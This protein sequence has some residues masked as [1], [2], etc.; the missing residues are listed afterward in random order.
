MLSPLVIGPLRLAISPLDV[1][2]QVLLPLA[3][4]AAAYALARLAIARMDLSPQ[5]RQRIRRLLRLAVILAAAVVLLALLTASFPK[6]LKSNL[7]SVWR[8]L[9]TPFITAGS[10]SISIVT[11]LLTIPVFLLANWLG[12]L[13]RLFLDRGL[14][15]RIVL[16]EEV[17]FTISNLVRYG[18]LV[19]AIIV[20][21]S[22]IGVNL[23]SMAVIFG[24]IGIGLGF[25]L[26]N[27][28]ANYVAGLVIFLERPLKEGDRILV[29]GLVG[30]VIQIRL[31]STIINTLT[32]ET[33][34]VPNSQLISN[35]IHNYSYR[36]KRIVIVNSV[37]VSYETDID[38][39]REV[40]L[41]VAGRNPFALGER[42]A[43]ARVTAFQNSGIQLELWTWIELATNKLDAVS[44]TNLEIW[45]AFKAA[46]IVIPFPQVDLHVKPT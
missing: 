6:E 4:L 27:V 35:N 22:V 3:V 9:S 7:A 24:V 18:V 46:G 36:D 5:R 44:W 11:I 33:I 42:G 40:L 41:E 31:R 30:D 2:L 20:G 39:A 8:I 10:S 15:R 45:R 34:I 38:R 26:Q 12:K 17:R 43:E 29:E 14:L 16:D 37:E 21:L 13:S 32:N 19:L 1:A 25:G 28:V 23:S